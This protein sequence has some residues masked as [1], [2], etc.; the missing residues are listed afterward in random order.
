MNNWCHLDSVKVEGPAVWRGLPCAGIELGVAGEIVLVHVA[1]NHNGS[2]LSI[3]QGFAS[4]I[5]C[6]DGEGQGVSAVSSLYGDV[7][8]ALA[9]RRFPVSSVCT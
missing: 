6:G 1:L 7:D 2:G 3:R 4:R 9:Q 8:T 5:L